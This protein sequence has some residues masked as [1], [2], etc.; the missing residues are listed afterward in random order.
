LSRNGI[1]P[2]FESQG[3]SVGALALREKIDPNGDYN[4]VDFL[5]QMLQ[6]KE[7]SLRLKRQ[8]GH[9]YGG[10]TRKIIYDMI[11]AELW[12]GSMEFKVTDDKYE[13]LAH[14]DIRR[15]QVDAMIFFAEKMKWP[16][17][18]ELRQTLNDF[19]QLSKGLDVRTWDW[20]VGLTLPGS[21]FPLTLL[22]GVHQA[23][24][25]LNMSPPEG[26]VQIRHGNFGLVFPQVSYWRNRSIIGRVLAVLPSVHEIG[27]WVGPC[28]SPIGL[29][30]YRTPAA[31]V[32][33]Q[34]RPPAFKLQNSTSDQQ[35]YVPLDGHLTWE[36][37][38]LPQT[39][40]EVCVLQKLH[41][42][43]VPKDVDSATPGNKVTAYRAKLDFLLL[44][45]NKI[46]SLTLYSHSIFV[47]A[48]PCKGTH[49]IDPKSTKHY[50]RRIYEISQLDKAELNTD[51]VT[52]INATGNGGHAIARAWCS[53]KG[54][55]AIIWKRDGDCCFKCGLMTTGKEG[56]DVDVLIIC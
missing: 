14:M 40:D 42:I 35:P 55:N 48:P 18:A 24:P 8:K 19:L 56:L 54:T 6:A 12:M 21:I 31:M 22:F 13:F 1:F 49:K 51:G 2:G 29:E 7:L 17:L 50:S 41:M 28:I 20:V 38:L 30:S 52:V 39:S 45:G 36:E 37:P 25:S 44:K 3:G 46:I 4:M 16:F 5:Y 10:I 53:E 34:T 15:R 9:S 32:Q 11:A 26:N 27:G 43:S 47:A 23:C 33:I